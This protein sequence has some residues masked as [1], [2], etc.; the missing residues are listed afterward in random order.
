MYGCDQT[1]FGCKLFPSHLFPFLLQPGGHARADGVW[2]RRQ[3]AQG[4]GQAIDQEGK[5]CLFVDV[6][7]HTLSGCF[8]QVAT[9]NTAEPRGGAAAALTSIYHQSHL[10]PL[11]AVAGPVRRPAQQAAGGAAAALGRRQL[12]PRRRLAAQRQEVRGWLGGVWSLD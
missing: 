3:A 12:Q 8:S 10:A 2:R 11:F 6:H 9:S 5:N 1:T 7:I 4:L